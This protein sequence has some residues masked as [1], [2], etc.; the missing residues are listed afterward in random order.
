MR[1]RVPMTLVALA[2]AAALL[3]AAAEASVTALKVRACQTGK[4]SKERLATFYGRMEAVPGTHRM[5]MRFTLI[6][7][8]S[9]GATIVNGPRKLARWKRSRPGVLRFGY[10]Q[11]V[12]GL[13]AGGAYAVIVEFRWVDSHGKTIKSLRRTSGDC[14]QDGDLANLAVTG[15]SAKP[16]DALGTELYF[17]NVVNRGTAAARSFQ[18]DLIVDGAAADA[19]EV[20]LLKPGE[21]ATLRISGPEC[22]A[23]VRAFADR[24]D[25]VPETTEDDNSLR[26]RCPAV[27]H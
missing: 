13:K 5:L 27:A 24:S 19:A 11:T 20:D 8:S 9:N 14:R 18:V 26:T 6:D 10:A 23:R 17:V 21:S 25:S 1:I 16:G 4:S 3:P 2:A 12:T 15:I 7:R 22:K